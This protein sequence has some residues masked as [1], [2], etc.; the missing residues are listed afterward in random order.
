[1]NTVIQTK[2]YDIKHKENHTDF[3]SLSISYTLTIIIYRK[4]YKYKDWYL[5]TVG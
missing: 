2:S 1:M 5:K 4:G 3:I